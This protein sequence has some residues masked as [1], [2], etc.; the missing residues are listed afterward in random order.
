MVEGYKN[1]TQVAQKNE[2]L[3]RVAARNERERKGRGVRELTHS[4][5]RSSLT[6]TLT[7]KNK[8]MRELATISEH[9]RNRV[10]FS[11]N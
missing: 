1:F 3:R 7:Q 4:R 2:A 5:K 11:G 10:G 9:E 6:L 8:A